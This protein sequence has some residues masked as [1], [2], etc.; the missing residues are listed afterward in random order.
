MSKIQVATK[1]LKDLEKYLLRE[2]TIRFI[3]DNNETFIPR[4]KKLKTFMLN[5]FNKYSQEYYS[6]PVEDECSTLED[7]DAGRSRSFRD[8]FLI[9]HYY[10]KCSLI[11]FIETW[12]NLGVCGNYCSDTDLYIIYARQAVGCDFYDLHDVSMIK[13]ELNGCSMRDVLNAFYTV[14]GLPDHIYDDP[15]E[16]EDDVDY[17]DDWDED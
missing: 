2:G 4:A 1:L 5:F 17:S 13:D 9:H 15:D 12:N 7:T 10:L 16:D 8:T 3:K 14:K 6:Q 11:D